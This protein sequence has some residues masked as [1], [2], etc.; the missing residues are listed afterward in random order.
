M[1]AASQIATPKR[2]SKKIPPSTTE[3][4]SRDRCLLAIGAA[5]AAY[6]D[7]PQAGRRGRLVTTERNHVAADIETLLRHFRKGV[8]LPTHARPAPAVVPGVTEIVTAIEREHWF[9]TLNMVVF[10]GADPAIWLEASHGWEKDQEAR[11]YAVNICS[12]LLAEHPQGKLPR[13]FDF[14]KPEIRAFTKNRAKLKPSA[15][16]G[17]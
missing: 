3:S 10:Q 12:H 11:A 15:T 8:R 5:L 2:P 1:K 16:I 17:P 7:D 14:L 13:V 9:R 4:G 6:Q